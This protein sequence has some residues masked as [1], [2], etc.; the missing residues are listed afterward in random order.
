M[1]LSKRLQ[2]LE[3]AANPC[4][5]LIVVHQ[6]EDE[7]REAARVRWQRDHPGVDLESALVVVIRRFA[8]RGQDEQSQPASAT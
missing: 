7:P 8:K 4:G 6:H 1:T 3:N 5:Q 2:K